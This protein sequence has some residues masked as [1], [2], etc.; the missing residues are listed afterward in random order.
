VRAALAL[1]LS[2]TRVLASIALCVRG[3]PKGAPLRPS[4]RGRPQVKFITRIQIRTT[5]W[6]RSRE[7]I[8]D[9]L[10]AE[11]NRCSFWREDDG[12]GS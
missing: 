7:R 2:L 5:P 4:Q 3:L 12:F 1:N 8:V 9:V 11:R 10:N 6:S